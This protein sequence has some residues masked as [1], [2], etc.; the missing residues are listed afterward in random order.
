MIRRPPRSTL[1]PY[2]TLFR[3]RSRRARGATPG[4]S[5]D[6]R[7]RGLLRLHRGVA[8]RGRNGG[9]GQGLDL[10]ARG[11]GGGPR[12]THALV[13]RAPGRDAGTRGSP[14][15]GRRSTA[16]GGSCTPA[17]AG[18]HAT[19]PA[20]AAEPAAPGAATRVGPAAAR[21]ATTS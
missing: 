19:D 3:S 18:D 17:T 16:A 11:P 15:G 8:P 5:Q 20:A 1:F 10:L 12:L 21:A 7:V 4:D 13:R 14:A 9:D 2:T 6:P